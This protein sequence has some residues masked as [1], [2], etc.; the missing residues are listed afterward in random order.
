MAL[1]IFV[2]KSKAECNISQQNW[3]KIDLKNYFWVL[4][5]ILNIHIFISR[6]LTWSNLPDI[7]RRISY[8]VYNYIED[9]LYKTQSKNALIDSKKSEDEI[10]GVARLSRNFF[11]YWKVYY[12]FL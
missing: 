8:Y 5:R 4:C 10:E 11:R 6:S 1:Y 2:R 9:E 3:M 12:R 7:Y